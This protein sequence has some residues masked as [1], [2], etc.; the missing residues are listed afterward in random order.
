MKR[1][2][3]DSHFPKYSQ[4]DWTVAKIIFTSSILASCSAFPCSLFIYS[5]EKFLEKKGT[6][7]NSSR[8]ATTTTDRRS[9]SSFF[10][11]SGGL[12]DDTCTRTRRQRSQSNVI[13]SVIESVISVSA[14]EFYYIRAAWF[15]SSPLPPP[16]KAARI[17]LF[18]FLVPLVFRKRNNSRA[19]KRQ[20]N[21]T[22][23]KY[24]EESDGETGKN[25]I[26]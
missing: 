16:L 3:K 11:R 5:F 26:K 14:R 21:V 9:L 15:P 12:I 17:F 23:R 10:P 24:R 2:T 19:L 4:S 20:C 8:G 18:A 13:K 22:D 6:K 25:I 1:A 7:W